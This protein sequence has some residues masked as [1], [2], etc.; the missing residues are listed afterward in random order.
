MS[1]EEWKGCKTAVQK[2]K[3][4][5]TEGLDMR[6]CDEEWNW[7]GC[8][9]AAVQKDMR[10]FTGPC[11]C[12]DEEWKGCKTAAEW[13]GCKTAAVQKDGVHRSMSL[14]CLTKSGKAV[15]WQQFR[16]IRQGSQKGAL[17]WPAALLSFPTP[18]L[19]QLC[20]YLKA[21]SHSLEL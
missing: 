20:M 18:S 3:R 2:D 12:L 17:L 8:K 15:K 16:K 10:G 1:V 6:V 7:K 4:G 9:T 13:K 19:V 5:S 11:V 14:V 21:F